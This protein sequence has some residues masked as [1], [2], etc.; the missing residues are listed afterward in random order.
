MTWRKVEYGEGRSVSAN[1]ETTQQEPRQQTPERECMNMTL[2]VWAV[3]S[4]GRGRAYKVLPRVAFGSGFV[5]G[6][7][8]N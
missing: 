5:N 1:P 3:V 8:G 4:P 7:L 2:R 6:H